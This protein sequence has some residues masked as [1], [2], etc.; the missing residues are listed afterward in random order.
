MT[1]LFIIALA[2][3]GYLIYVLIKP[4]KF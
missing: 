3:F 2:V 1:A 4:E